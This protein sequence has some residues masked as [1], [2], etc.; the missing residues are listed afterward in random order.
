MHID[1]VAPYSFIPVYKGLQDI[2]KIEEIKNKTIEDQ[3]N[4]ELPVWTSK[5]GATR[6]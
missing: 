5:N 1:L 2:N 3:K 4:E 6:K